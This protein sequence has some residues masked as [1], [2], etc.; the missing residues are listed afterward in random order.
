MKSAR[1][2]S[3]ASALLCLAMLASSCAREKNIPDYAATYRRLASS[4]VRLCVQMEPLRGSRLGLA[5]ADSLLFSYSKEET[6][7]AV[8]RLKNL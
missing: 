7:D 5:S 8:K 2:A 1:S 3:A 4:A 6:A